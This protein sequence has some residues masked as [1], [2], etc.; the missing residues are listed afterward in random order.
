MKKKLLYF[1]SSNVKIRVRGRNVNLFIKRLI[2]NKI[3]IIKVI[4]KS[5]KEVLLIVDYNDIDRINRIKTI[6]NI[7]IISYYGILRIFKYIKKNIFIISF[8]IIG[9]IIIYILSN[10]IFSIDII[11]SN[12]NIISLVDNELKS[13][14]IKKYSFVKSY[15]EIEKIKKDI[16]EGNRDNLEWLE[17]I[18]SGTKYIV[19]VEERIINK[20]NN[21]S[22]NYS[23][24]AKKNAIIKSITAYSGEKVKEVNTYVKKG[25]EV[26]SSYV[27]MPNN[28]RVFSSAN[29]K[30]IG[31]VWYNVSIDYPYFYNEVLYTGKKRRVISFNIL[32]KSYS[33]FNFKKYKSFDINRKYIFKNSIIPISFS[34][35]YEY[36]T[37][38]INDIYTYDTAKEKAIMVA[39]D[40][41][42]EKYKDIIDI[43]KVII[44][45]EEETSSMISLNLFITCNEDITEY[46][47]VIEEDNSSV[48]NE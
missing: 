17:I 21:N 22:N 6:Y 34:I 3:N 35:D 26:I 28:E 27:T 46:K 40:K 12:S 15:K 31:E 10:I 41:L 13:H 36:E 7:D 47:E 32:S 42:K 45:Y 24:V 8:L 11:H 48:K 1:S 44:T 20:D 38:I 18:R 39:K 33:L 29:G 30:V 14:G 23:I 4:P 16:L 2:K 25:E 19:R 5:Y 9:I 43:D 37:K